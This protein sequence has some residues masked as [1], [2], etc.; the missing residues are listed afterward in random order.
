LSLV[1]ILMAFMLSDSTSEPEVEA[2]TECS[3]VA[4]SGLID[5]STLIIYTA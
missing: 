2:E 3:W 5:P 1:P 4:L